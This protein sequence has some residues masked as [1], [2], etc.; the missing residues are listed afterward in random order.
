[1]EI[2]D[3]PVFSLPVCF[4]P[5]HPVRGNDGRVTYRA[6]TAAL[7]DGYRNLLVDAIVP[8]HPEEEAVPVIVWIHGGGFRMG[9]SEEVWSPWFHAM[10]E[11]VLAAGFAFASLTYRFSSEAIF[12]A[13]LVDVRAGIRYLRHYAA[14]LGLDPER[15]AVWGGSAGAQL[16]LLLALTPTLD[17]GGSVGVAGPDGPVRAVVDF[18]GLADILALPENEQGDD[19]IRAGLLGGPVPER[20]ELARQASPITHVHADAPPVLAFH[21]TADG[22]IPIEQSR[23]FIQRAR[24]AGM[25]AELIE[26]E[27]A[28][29]GFAT[30]DMEDI[31]DRSVAFLGAHLREAALR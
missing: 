28:D 23:R 1:V 29:H 16:A 6:E 26:V 3:G 30:I 12:P 5:S 10:Q 20:L 22:L 21:G 27:G 15:F 13:Q 9:A 11:K 14:L 2:P 7:I 31:L 8:A 25:D 18:Y 17:L 4:P 19:G 24:E